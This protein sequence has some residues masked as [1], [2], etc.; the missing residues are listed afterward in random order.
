M[1]LPKL[2]N[3]KRFTL[4]RPVGS[5]DALLLAQLA[6]REKIANK[7]TMVALNTLVLVTTWMP[8]PKKAMFMVS[9]SIHL[10]IG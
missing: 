1:D 2:Q 6:E 4:P 10:M 3:G 7:P 9:G 5:A 8:S